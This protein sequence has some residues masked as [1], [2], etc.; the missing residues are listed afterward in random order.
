MNIKSTVF[1]AVIGMDLVDIYR[2]FRG[3]FLFLF[4]GYQMK[5]RKKMRTKAEATSD[6]ILK[7][8]K[9]GSFEMPVN[10]SKI[11]NV[12]ISEK[13]WLDFISN[14]LFRRVGRRYLWVSCYYLFP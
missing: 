7:M 13:E 14:K 6:V 1:W 2:M 5:V 10:I 8:E 4:S 11:T 3:K 9:S 12:H